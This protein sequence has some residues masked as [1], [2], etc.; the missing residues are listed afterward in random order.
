MSRKPTFRDK[1]NVYL[2]ALPPSI[3]VGGRVVELG[4]VPDGAT[5]DEHRRLLTEA[6]VWVL[7]AAEVVAGRET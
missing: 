4:R 1:L 7:A 5:D 3:I 2:A 6:V